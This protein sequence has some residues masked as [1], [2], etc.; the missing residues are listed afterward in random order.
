MSPAAPPLLS[1]RLPLS[2]AIALWRA[3]CYCY[4]SL[5]APALLLT[6][7]HLLLGRPLT[8]LGAALSLSALLLLNF[9]AHRA[10]AVLVLPASLPSAP[11]V[12]WLAARVRQYGGEGAARALDGLEAHLRTMRAAVERARGALEASP[13]W[14]P[15]ALT[16]PDGVQTQGWVHGWWGGKAPAKGMV[17]YLGGNGEH[18]ALSAAPVLEAWGAQGYGVL[19]ADYRG[20][21]TASGSAATRDGLVLDALTA[22][23]FLLAPLA[24][25][26]LALPPHKVLVV[27]HSLGGGIGVEAVALCAARGVN[28]V[29]DR[30][31]GRLTDAAVCL[32]L[33]RALLPARPAAGGAGGGAAGRRL[34]GAAA[35]G[36]GAHAAAAA[37][38]AS[39]PPGADASGFQGFAA[40]AIFRS[41]MR[42]VAGWEYDSAALWPTL[43]PHTKIVVFS[44][45]DGVIHAPASLAVALTSGSS[46]SSSSSSSGG[47]GGGGAGAL[48]TEQV[49]CLCQMDCARGEE[50]AYAHNRPF[51]ASERE[52]LK[53]VCDLASE[54]LGAGN[55][56]GTGARVAEARRV[57]PA[58]W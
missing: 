28:V 44:P 17:L 12:P 26:G 6:S 37:G 49:G 24:E 11:W 20:V 4:Y 54:V 14:Q 40:R 52:K 35:T 39:P 47:G 16:A 48:P 5:A 10:A 56:L 41:V 29:N 45:A 22:L 7:S 33:P 42:G 46:G 2:P 9:L 18:A 27:G 38:A 32:F 23:S 25:G 13:R 58:T 15:V 53:R 43:P 1:F 34:D 30:S 19:V 51:N 31:F 8:R 57:L 3:R 36:G 21:S 50:G 55:V